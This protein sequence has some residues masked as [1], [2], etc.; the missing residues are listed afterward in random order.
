MP[1]TIADAYFLKSQINF[2]PSP[3]SLGCPSIAGTQA[4]TATLRSKND[5]NKHRGDES[6]L[7]VD[8]LTDSSSHD[9]SITIHVYVSDALQ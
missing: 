9:L 1:N 2:G 4:I 5:C 3:S 8:D 7:V 6:H